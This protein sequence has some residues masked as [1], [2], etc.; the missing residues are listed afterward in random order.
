[1]ALGIS[2][3]QTL[4]RVIQSLH[5]AQTLGELRQATHDGLAVVVPGDCH[6]M[7]LLAG[8]PAD[9]DQFFARPGTY[10]HGEILYMLGNAAK[11]PLVEPFRRG[12]PGAVSVSQVV[13]ARQWRNTEFYRESG[14]R[15]LGL[16]HELAALVPNVHPTGMASVSVLRGRDFS[17]RDRE[18]IDHLR[19]HLGLAWR[20]VL[21]RQAAASPAKVRTAFPMLSEREA[22]VLF[23]ITEG[24]ENREIA[25]ILERSL[26]TVQEHV[27]NIIRKLGLE[28]RHE[29]TVFALRNLLGG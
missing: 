21:A 4:L 29:T 5:A 20:R 24:K 7:V 18:M 11:H 13:S 17:E 6:D 19:P 8:S 25:E 1:M 9:E 16:K 14:Y 3:Y 26:H 10:T 2:E 28:N 22:V 12:D 23:W 15:R 27:E